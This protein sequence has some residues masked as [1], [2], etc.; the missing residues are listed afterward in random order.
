MRLIDADELYIDQLYDFGGKCYVN[1]VADWI[2]EQPTV[3]ARI[4][5]QGK[6]EEIWGGELM[7][8]NCNTIQEDNPHFY[9]FCPF[10]GAK[11]NNSKY[12]NWS[13]K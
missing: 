1:E 11:M 8:S 5:T 12:P 10:C 9:N 3:E 13:G 6:W 7:C 2:N 4:T